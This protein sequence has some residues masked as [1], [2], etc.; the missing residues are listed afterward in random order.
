LLQRVR[1]FV[2][3]L[4]DASHRVSAQARRRMAVATRELDDATR[5]AARTA[6]AA[7][8]RERA[9]LD[10]AHSRVDELATRRTGE[11]AAHLDACARRVAELGRRATRAAAQAVTGRERELVTVANHHLSRATL[12]LDAGEGAVRALD[13]RRVLERGYSI[14]RDTDGRVLK[15]AA[16]V[17]PGA[18]LETELA[19]GLITSRV[20]T[21]TEE[22]GD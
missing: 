16:A 5:R 11:V 17:A 7:L 19:T 13:P 14:T 3:G 10:R 6:P 1:D 8:V 2:G 18:R 20:E 9:R 15:R 12:R 4:D 21:S 22:P